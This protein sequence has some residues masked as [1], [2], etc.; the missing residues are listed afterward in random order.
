MGNI[1]DAGFGPCFIF[2]IQIKVDEAALTGI[3]GK[4]PEI[5]D[6]TEIAVA[7]AVQGVEK[8]VGALCRPGLAV[9]R[10]IAEPDAR[11]EFPGLYACIRIGQKCANR[12]A[13]SVSAI[14]VIH[15]APG[16]D[17]GAFVLGKETAGLPELQAGCGIAPGHP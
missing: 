10:Q 17:A 15:I 2:E 4:R 14:L 8:M 16:A 3:V 9:S 13:V 7:V 11:Q 12:L 6:E 5:V 1:A